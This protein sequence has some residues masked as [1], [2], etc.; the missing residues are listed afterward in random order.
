MAVL[1]RVDPLTLLLIAA[2]AVVGSIVVS[3]SIGLSQSLLTAPTPYRDSHDLLFLFGSVPEQNVEHVGLSR[4]EIDAYGQKLQGLDTFGAF[5]LERSVTVGASRPER[6]VCIYADDGF[7][8][9]LGID[10]ALGSLPL[11]E[12]EVA[13]GHSYWQ[14]RLAKSDAVIGAPI[15]L[16]GQ[17]YTIGAVLEESFR[18][19]FYRNVDMV[20]DL[21]LAEKLLGPKYRY[22][23]ETT[24]LLGVGRLSP[25]TTHDQLELEAKAVA[26]EEAEK[27]ASGIAAR[28]A[29]VEPLVEFLF[30]GSTSAAA[31]FIAACALFVVLSCTTNIA[32]VMRA[33]F[34]ARQRDLRT[35][36]AL[37]ASPKTILLG[38]LWPVLGAVL[39]ACVLGVWAASELS[40]HLLALSGYAP[41]NFSQE[42]VGLASSLLAVAIMAAVA[43]ASALHQLRKEVLREG[44]RSLSQSLG[45]APG[46]G[47]LLQL[48]LGIALCAALLM[49]ALITA[50]SLRYLSTRP[51][52]MATEI[53]TIARE[54]SGPR[55]DDTEARDSEVKRT[56]EALRNSQMV[57]QATI[58]GPTIAPDA[59]RSVNV[60]L[61]SQGGVT[62][63]AMRHSVSADYF[64]TMSIP[65]IT[66][67]SFAT[68]RRTDA[69]GSVVVSAS[70]AL[71]LWPNG[72]AIGQE[73]ELRPSPGQAKTWRVVG[74]AA[75]VA[76]RGIREK[77]LDLYTPYWQTNDRE[78]YFLAKPAPGQES[79]FPAAA[80]AIMYELDPDLAAPRFERLDD[81]FKEFRSN[82]RFLASITSA[83]AA[84]AFTIAAIGIFGGIRA[85]S[86]A[87]RREWVLK[88]ALG[89]T[90][91][92]VL[93]AVLLKGFLLAT[94]PGLVGI[95][96][97]LVASR[98]LSAVLYGIRP[99]DP[100][101][102]AAVLL[103][104]MATG[105]LASTP[106][107]IRASRESVRSALA[108]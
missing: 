90:Q 101:S 71:A 61:N 18:G 50:Q 88:R 38:E 29:N 100:P 9:A 104:M 51:I 23:R 106:S 72:D 99:L 48:G 84:I 60:V 95:A 87:R 34:E 11:S 45:R 21:G 74:V 36:I 24:F 103:T 2:S 31:R 37:G 83:F 93:Q 64:E 82:D 92:Q 68:T 66:G 42:P 53:T 5:T 46:L 52:G 80:V 102:I 6:R 43:A 97:A 7:F 22:D 14:S 47:H 32:L 70:L 35:R 10:V 77:K 78:F 55:Y 58:A 40:P 4:P 54:F 94:L 19:P 16:D 44:V 3:G 105:V 27:V 75:D 8:N 12:T 98:P 65:L 41:A 56:L 89:L 62:A 39:L 81:R 73:L 25:Q 79:E 67:S 20:L 76:H 96:A 86:A 59:Y 69:T 49:A 107:A 13:V 57:S 30:G 26:R 63:D 15:V 108:D 28:S 91:Q 1:R 33:R 17:P 85:D